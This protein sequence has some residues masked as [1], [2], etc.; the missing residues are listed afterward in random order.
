MDHPAQAMHTVRAIRGAYPDMPVF[1]RARD[2]KHT[3]ELLDAGATMVVPE[4]LEAGLNLARV[5]LQ[6]IGLPEAE[7]SRAIDAERDS[8]VSGHD[9]RPR[10]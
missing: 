7:L 10:A 2:E 4:T 9:R 1:A 8:R 6:Q 3:R 5:A